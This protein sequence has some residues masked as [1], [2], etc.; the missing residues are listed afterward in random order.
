MQLLSRAIVLASSVRKKFSWGHNSPGVNSQWG[1]WITVGAAEKSQQCR[2]YLAQ[3][4]KFAFER[5]QYKGAYHD[6]QTYPWM[7]LCSGS[8]MGAPNFDHR[9]AGSTTGEPNLFFAPAPSNLV[10]PLGFIEWL[11]VVICIWSALCVTSQ[12]D[13]I[14][15]F[16]SQRFDEVC[17]HNMHIHLHALLFYVITL[18]TNYQHSKLG[19]QR[20]RHSTLW[21]SSS[22][23]KKYQAVR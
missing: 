5:A 2:K 18:S 23:F 15:M 6:S 4:S 13:V 22:Y 11:M 16:P 20:K 21:H 7:R 1:R 9:G 19:Y 17:W 12:F 8:T 14:F 10:T 3:Y